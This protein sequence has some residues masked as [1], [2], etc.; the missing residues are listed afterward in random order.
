PP[1]GARI[2]ITPRV[3]R[4]SDNNLILSGHSGATTLVSPDAEWNSGSNVYSRDTKGIMKSTA[5]ALFSI[6]ISSQ[7]AYADIL[8][9]IVDESRLPYDLSPSKYENSPSKYEN[10]ASKYENSESKY[11]NSPSKYENSASKYENGPNGE[12]RVYTNDGRVLGYYVFSE[13]GILNFFSYE[14][15][16]VAY[17]PAG[18][19]TQSIFSNTGWCGIIV[20]DQNQLVLGLSQE[21]YFN[22]LLGN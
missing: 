20:E 11:S 15:R 19:H 6:I 17:L 1:P 18:G 4:G 12:R 13:D 10:S 14:S 22:F 5:L 3:H 16:R 8:A 9:V 21:C 2:Q 7:L